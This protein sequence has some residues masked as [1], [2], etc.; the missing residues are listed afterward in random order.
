MAGSNELAKRDVP[1]VI[2]NVVVIL[3][4]A[5]DLGNLGRF[6]AALRMTYSAP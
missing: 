6:F 4:V 1:R 5:K 2:V 3:S